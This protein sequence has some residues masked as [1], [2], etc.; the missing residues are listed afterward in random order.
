MALDLAG[1]QCEGINERREKDMTRT[2]VSRHPFA[3]LAAVFLLS[4]FLLLLVGITGYFSL[5]TGKALIGN[6]L[7][8]SVGTKEACRVLEPG[9]ERGVPSLDIWSRWD[10]EWYLLI[11]KTGYDTAGVLA[12]SRIRTRPEASLGFFPLYPFL[13]RCLSPVFG[14]ILSGI[15]ISNISL[16]LSL[17]LLIELARELWP[18]GYSE[19]IGVGAGLAVLLHPLTLFFSA[20]YSESLYLALS[21][22]AFLAVIRKSRSL[23]PA[24]LTVAAVL[25]RPFG[26]II[27]LPMVLRW[28]KDNDGIKRLTVIAVSALFGL[29]MY[30]LYCYTLVGDPLAFVTRQQHWR[31]KSFFPGW[32]LIRWCL[33]GP[34]IHGASSSTIEL[35]IALVFLAVLP[36]AFKYLPLSLAS[37]LAVG[38]AIPLSSTLWSFGRISSVLFPVYLLIGCFF[39][40]YR[41]R[42]VW[43]YG[44]SFLL[45]LAAMAFFAAGWWVG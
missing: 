17:Y 14:G 6:N 32:A 5:P 35:L 21:L 34:T 27:L 41:L 22:G 33:D 31:G 24:V 38:I 42:V 18:D 19:M 43:L 12:S 13:I 4:R 28:R 9:E 44:V 20:V 26:I 45:S 40:R 16:L 15:L 8:I 29:G 23:L 30:L 10:S 25:T 2:Y 36:A 7:R 1:N 37:Y 11:S 3:I 39:S